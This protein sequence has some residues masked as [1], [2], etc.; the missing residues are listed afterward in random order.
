[1]PLYLHVGSAFYGIDWNG[2]LPDEENFER[3]EVVKQ[4]TH[5]KKVTLMN[6]SVLS[7]T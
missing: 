1:M 4:L 6:Y 3:V 5:F 7:P 2:P